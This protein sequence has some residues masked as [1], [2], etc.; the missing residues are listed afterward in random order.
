MEGHYKTSEPLP[1]GIQRVPRDQNSS[2]LAKGKYSKQCYWAFF[3]VSKNP[4]NY[5]G[6]ILKPKCGLN[7]LCKETITMK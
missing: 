7:L 3:S 4:L 5:C 2:S 6:N 1:A